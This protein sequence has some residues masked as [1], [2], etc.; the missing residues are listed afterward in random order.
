LCCHLTHARWRLQIEL[1]TVKGAHFYEMGMRA[2]DLIVLGQVGSGFLIL[3]F[4]YFEL[5]LS[6]PFL[7]IIRGPSE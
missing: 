7:H 1:L 4:E 6:L 5:I 3:L 2:A